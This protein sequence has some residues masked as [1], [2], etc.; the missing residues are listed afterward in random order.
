MTESVSIENECLQNILQNYVVLT[1]PKSVQKI[2]DYDMKGVLSRAAT[3]LRQ[4][5][6]MTKHCVRAGGLN[7]SL[8]LKV[9]NQVESESPA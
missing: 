1:E 9:S 4:V 6:H 3:E 2:R 8:K 5:E 7:E